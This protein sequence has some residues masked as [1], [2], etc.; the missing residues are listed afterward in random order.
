MKHRLTVLVGATPRALLH[1]IEY[2]FQAQP[3]F[4]ILGVSCGAEGVARQGE[5]LRP[6]LIAVNV[7]PVKTGVC[8]TVRLIKRSCP[9][10]KLILIF[11]VKGLAP[12]ARR[13][14]ADAC[15]EAE[16]LLG[17]LLPTAQRLASTAQTEWLTTERKSS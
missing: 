2:V 14:G 11:P 12:S 4:E 13:C 10:S 9:S 8:R 5:R 7:K 6:E 17:R 16:A 1:V 3:E 15:L